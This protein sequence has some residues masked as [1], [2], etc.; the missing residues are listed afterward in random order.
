MEGHSHRSAIIDV[1]QHLKIKVPSLVTFETKDYPS[2]MVI[3]LNFEQYGYIGSLNLEHYLFINNNI[4]KVNEI[5]VN[6][7]NQKVIIPTK[8][9]NEEKLPKKLVLNKNEHLNQI[10]KF[11]KKYKKA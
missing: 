1:D 8:A 9:S 7:I 6:L 11:N 3:T 10:E 2:F 5:F 4:I